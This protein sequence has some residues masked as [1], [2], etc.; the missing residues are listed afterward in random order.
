MEVPDLER[1]LPVVSVLS[2]IGQFKVVLASVAMI[3]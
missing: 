1:F 2:V 3:R